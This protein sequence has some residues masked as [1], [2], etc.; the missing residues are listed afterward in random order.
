[1]MGF[2]DRNRDGRV[3]SEELGRLPSPI[4]DR[5]RQAG[6][7]ARRGLS[8]SDLGRAFDRIRQ[9]REQE[10]GGF[11]RGEG[12]D[13]GRFDRTG[14]DDRNRSESASRTAR[15][16][17]KPKERVTIDLPTAFSEGDTDQDGQIAFYEWRRWRRAET[18]T[19]Y[20]YDHNGD[21]FLTPRELAKGPS[22]G[23]QLLTITQAA[24][25]SEPSVVSTPAASTP[26]AP[27]RAV[28]APAAN[29][30]MDSP[31]ARQARSMFRLMDRDRSGNI[32]AEEWERSRRI[33][34]M[35]ESAG[36]DLSK[37]MTVDVFVG[38]YVQLSGND[39]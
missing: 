25:G 23:V 7:D 24:G 32:T 6:V 9:I 35:F 28:S 10:G 21:G 1:M 29:V 3:D 15:S 12:E 16:T 20:A 30:D 17:M 36:I 11:G 8:A 33:K 22:D 26:T 38:Q 34:P 18:Q 19:F 2:M 4:Q 13:R 14:S 39:S 31:E 5:L 37:P 27:I